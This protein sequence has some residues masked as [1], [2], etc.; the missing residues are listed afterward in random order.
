M[1]LCKKA[2]LIGFGLV[3]LPSALCFGDLVVS[4]VPGGPPK[5]GSFK[6]TNSGLTDLILD[7]VVFTGSLNGNQLVTSRSGGISPGS[8][9]P[10][11][12]N[13]S[14]LIKFDPSGVGVSQ[15]GLR[16]GCIE[17][18]THTDDTV[19]LVSSRETQCQVCV[20]VYVVPSLCFNSA[21]TIHSSANFTEIW[22]QSVEVFAAS[23]NGMYYFATG[24]NFIFDGGVAIVNP[25]L[26]GPPGHPRGLRNYFDD[27]FLRCLTAITVDSIPDPTDTLNSYAIFAKTLSTGRLDSTIIWE[28]IWEQS[29]NP[30]YSDFLAKTVRVVNISG[31]D[32]P[33]VILGVAN[34]ID[35]PAYN[36]PRNLSFDTSFTATSDGKI[37]TMLVFSGILDPFADT[38]GPPYGC[39]PNDKYFGAITIPNGTASASPVSPRGT[40]AFRNRSFLPA[41]SWQDSQFVNRMDAIGYHPT[42]NLAD[43]G[44]TGMGPEYFPPNPCPNVGSADI[45]FV[46]GAKKVT[47]PKND[48]V[49][50]LASRYGLQGLAAGFDTL[51][52][53]GPSESFSVIFVASLN[54]VNNL[55]KAADS[56]VS[57]Y[58]LNANQ[59]AGGDIGLFHRGDLN[60]DGIL[61]SADVVRV[62]NSVFLGQH[63]ITPLCTADLNLDNFLSS[64]DVVNELNYVFLG[65]LPTPAYPPMPELMTCF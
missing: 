33:D 19:G 6:I 44:L 25:A 50:K 40:V 3:L 65:T 39:N 55:M 21:D 14:I 61:T 28:T 24:E 11:L 7:S 56:A 1:S 16:S 47:L 38:L 13:A 32:I 62:L 35:V 41:N 45:G 34:D 5:E 29:T 15:S 63:T 57:W 26:A 52:L 42:R 49:G 60:G 17:I 64:A 58:Y 36:G 9:I 4:L 37:Y 43:T 23:A 18:W 27:Q 12:T 51:T 30:A 48:I 54:G 53:E 2:F 22:S 20:N 59:Q 46:I 8:A 10:Q 31:A